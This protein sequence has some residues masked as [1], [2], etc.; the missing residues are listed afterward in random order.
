MA[1]ER[2]NLFAVFLYLPRPAVLAQARWEGV[3]H[4]PLLCVRAAWAVCTLHAA[5]HWLLLLGRLESHSHESSTSLQCF[6]AQIEA[7]DL[8]NDSDDDDDADVGSNLG[9]VC[10]V[11]AGWAGTGPQPERL[12]FPWF[13]TPQALGAAGSNNAVNMQLSARTLALRAAQVKQLGLARR[14]VGMVSSLQQVSN[15]FPAPTPLSLA[16]PLC[17]TS[18][19]SAASAWGGC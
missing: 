14:R 1:L 8:E 4:L 2:F 17:R 12:A 6:R 5:G 16:P 11:Q 3:F 18:W 13:L 9:C 10:E 15:S 19:P 7:D